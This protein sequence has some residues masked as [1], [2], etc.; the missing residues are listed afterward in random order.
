MFLLIYVKGPTSSLGT[1]AIVS[2]AWCTLRCEIAEKNDS[3][4]IAIQEV[5]QNRR[6]FDD[7]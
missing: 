2:L 6:R 4:P 7:K 1:R 5:W 3:S